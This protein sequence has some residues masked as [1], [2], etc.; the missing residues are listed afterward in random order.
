MPDPW[1]L[2]A[3]PGPCGGAIRLFCLPYAGGGAAVFRN[4]PGLLGPDV[5]A[6]PIQLPGRANRL[7]EEPFTRLLS[8]AETLADALEPFLDRQ[9]SFFGY[10]LG[11]L[12]AF[13]VTRELR[14]RGALPPAR[15][16]VCARRGPRQRDPGPPV[17][18]LTGEAFVREVERRYGGI[19]P[20]VRREP[21]LM[22]LLLPS[23]R[24]DLEMLE[25]YEYAAG[26]PLDCPIT[27]LGGREDPRAPREALEAWRW[28]TRALHSHH[29]FPGGHFFLREEE[30]AVTG[31]VRRELRR[32]LAAAPGRTTSAREVG[33]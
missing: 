7:R 24:A 9:Y 13:E 21:E 19:P 5:E 31:L 22:K 20:A 26:Q 30:G 27:S 3:W 11:A 17:H 4:W 6:V 1:F 10:S 18:L 33:R 25:T 2:P 15:L 32:D 14:R 8:L 28:E 23:L 16:F 12:V 29:E